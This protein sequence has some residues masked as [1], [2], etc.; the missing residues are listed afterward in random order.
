MQESKDSEQR[1]REFV[2]AA[3]K[4]F[5]KKGIVDTTVNS[6]V[7]EMNVAKGLFYY[8]FN[9]KDDVIEAISEKYSQAFNAMMQQSLDQQNYTE[10]LG[11]FIDNSVDSFR[12]LIDSMHGENED[13]DLTQLSVR[14]I[15]EAKEA[16]SAKLQ[17]LLEEGNRR[18]EHHIKKAEYLADILIGGIVNIA[19]KGE[20]TAEE[21]KE[22]IWDL[23]DQAGRDN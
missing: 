14:S 23:I 13:V 21:I 16:A 4:L 17:E 15:D 8:Y 19:E 5:R 12:R 1:R 22:M 11:K 18:G 3:E 9:S 6:I 7:K 10:K 20:A 2:E